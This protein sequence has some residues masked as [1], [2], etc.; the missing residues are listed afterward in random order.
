MPTPAPFSEAW[1]L[2]D[3]EHKLGLPDFPHEGTHVEQENW[4]RE[5]ARQDDKKLAAA[6]G[7]HIAWKMQS[8]VQVVP[9][10]CEHVGVRVVSALKQLQ[11]NPEDANAQEEAGDH[12]ISKME[13]GMCFFASKGAA[14]VASDVHEKLLAAVEAGQFKFNPSDGGNCVLSGLPLHVLFKGWKGVAATVHIE[15]IPDSFRANYHYTALTEGQVPEQGAETVC[16][17]MPTGE[18][19]IAD[20]FRIDAFQT[21]TR[22][23]DDDNDHDIGTIGGRATRT[24]RYANELGIGHIAC[25]SPDVLQDEGVVKVGYLDVETQTNPANFKGRIS[26]D[27]RWTTLVD[28]GHLVELLTP[29]LGAEEA[30]R[31]VAEYLLQNPDI[32]RLKVDQG[33]HHLTFAGTSRVF[34]TTIKDRFQAEGLYLEDFEEPAFVLTRESLVPTSHLAIDPVAERKS[35]RP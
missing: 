31:Q 20:W 34:Q 17:P 5:V 18:L 27:L 16:L 32:I 30:E 35:P 8:G 9:P 1:T 12:F 15:K 10:F 4:R 24:R 25:R 29:A 14:L 22:P 11:A 23:L 21:L 33:T 19:L 13:I 7:R 6:L 28:R 3:T 26:A 2:A